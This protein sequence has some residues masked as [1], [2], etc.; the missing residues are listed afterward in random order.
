MFYFTDLVGKKYGKLTVLARAPNPHTAH[1]YRGVYWL[2]RCDCGRE[3]IVAAR[4]LQR[5]ETLACCR[6]C[7]WNKTGFS[8]IRNQLRKGA[9]KRHIQ[10][11]L[12][13]EE[14][15]D[16]VSKPCIYCGV[17]PPVRVSVHYHGVTI[18]AHGL[19]RIDS[20]RGY[21]ADNVVP[22]CTQCNVAKH[23]HSVQDFLDHALQIVLHNSA[24][25]QELIKR[26][27]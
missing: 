9:R 26:V 16:L 1:S 5:G 18:K 8:V 23:T 20:S 7:A 15:A 17:E 25:Y 21:T 10:F 6:F 2:C 14:I 11:S 13:I 24:L 22:C 4:Y 27:G 3:R 12:S 19:D